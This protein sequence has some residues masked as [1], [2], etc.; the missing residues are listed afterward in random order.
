MTKAKGYFKTCREHSVLV[1]LAFYKIFRIFYLPLPV[2]QD[3]VR[4]VGHVEIVAESVKPD[5]CD[6]GVWQLEMHGQGQALGDQ[7]GQG[8][9]RLA[10]QGP[11]LALSW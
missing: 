3:L 2:E 1:V 6:G 8:H 11:R 9:Q 4:D 7:A 10:A 5:A